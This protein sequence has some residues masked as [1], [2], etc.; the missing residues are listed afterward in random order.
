MRVAALVSSD[1]IIE[2]LKKYVR[3]EQQ[4][5][6]KMLGEGWFADDSGDESRRQTGRTQCQAVSY[7]IAAVN[8]PGQR[9]AIR[10]H[11]PTQACNRQCYKRVVSIYEA[12]RRTL[13][14]RGRADIA[15]RFCFHNESTEISYVP[16]SS[17]HFHVTLHA[18]QTMI[19]RVQEGLQGPN[20]SPNRR[21]T[22]TVVTCDEVGKNTKHQPVHIDYCEQTQ[23]F[24]FTVPLTVE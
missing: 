5:L 11:V 19:T 15:G 1:E 14:E 24:L 9:I 18:L 17:L 6:L 10:D 22:I 4:L 3:P 8:S 23:D 13:V 12:L 20:C 16:P 21:E 2:E 7:L